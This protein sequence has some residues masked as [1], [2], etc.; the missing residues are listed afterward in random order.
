MTGISAW[1]PTGISHDAFVS[2]V[3]DP[4]TVQAATIAPRYH[5]VLYMTVNSPRCAGWASSII[6]SGAEPCERFEHMPT[7][8]RPPMNMPLPLEGIARI[9]QQRRVPRTKMK[10]SYSAR[11]HRRSKREYQSRRPFC[12]RAGRQD[13]TLSRR[14]PLFNR[15][16]P[17]VS[18]SQKNKTLKAPISKVALK[19]PRV[20]PLGLSKSTGKRSVHSLHKGRR[21]NSRSCQ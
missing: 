20:A 19:S 7:G 12:G 11:S 16:F 4:N 10:C 13:T 17:C 15:R 21:S 3:C 14:Q 18:F 5:S 6:S 9:R 2:Y 1:M 8:N